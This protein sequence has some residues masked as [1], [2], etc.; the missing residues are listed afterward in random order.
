MKR[1]GFFLQAARDCGYAVV[2]WS[3]L[4]T[5]HKTRE[6][7]IPVENAFLEENTLPRGTFDVVYHCEFLVHFEDPVNALRTMAAYLGPE[8]V[9]A[10]EVGLMAES[11]FWYRLTGKISLGHHLWFYSDRALTVLLDRARAGHYKNPVLW[12][13]SVA[14]DPGWRACRRSSRASLCK[15][16]NVPA[17]YRGTFRTSFGSPKVFVIAKPRVYARHA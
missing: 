14:V 15:V 4:P 17:V 8:G 6:L 3:L 16:R 12:A 10:F 13:M 5:E 1:T 7:G 2:D 9:L 11:R